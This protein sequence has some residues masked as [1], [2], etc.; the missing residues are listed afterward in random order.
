MLGVANVNYAAVTADAAFRRT[1]LV[2]NAETAFAALAPAAQRAA[3]SASGSTLTNW[4]GLLHETCDQQ[5]VEQNW[6]LALH[7]LAR[8]TLAYLDASAAAE[9]LANAVPQ[10]CRERLPAEL[11]PWLDLYAA[12]AA[13]DG[14]SMGEL[15]ERLLDGTGPG[16]P[17][18]FAL[19]AAMLGRL[20]SHEP[21]RVTELYEKHE[22]IAGDLRSSPEIRLMLA[23]AKNRRELNTTEAPR[24]LL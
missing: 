19:T 23:L 11:R 4:F 7:E 18:Y 20:A 1:Q 2:R 10:A 6:T 13:R 22:D 3:G 21:E 14:R 16:E 24:S 17:K 12:V 8:E 5:G 9:L 15:G